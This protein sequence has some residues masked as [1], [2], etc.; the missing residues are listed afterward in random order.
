MVLTDQTM[1]YDG[2]AAA[3]ATAHIRDNPLHASPTL[4]T[5]RD[6]NQ[7]SA[8]ERAQIIPEHNGDGPWPTFV[9]GKPDFDKMDGVQRRAYHIAR[10]NQKFG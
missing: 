2:S 9:D 5:S 4:A 7:S 3:R 1:S 10:L 8:P 6:G